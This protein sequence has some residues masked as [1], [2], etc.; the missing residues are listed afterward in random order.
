MGCVRIIL[1]AEYTTPY[2]F[3]SSN[4]GGW[5]PIRSGTTAPGLRLWAVC[6]SPRRNYWGR[7]PINYMGT[8]P[9]FFSQNQLGSVPK[10]SKVYSKVYY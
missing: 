6:P 4:C 9:Q 10:V 7:S 3:T 8:E 1:A 5:P 2:G